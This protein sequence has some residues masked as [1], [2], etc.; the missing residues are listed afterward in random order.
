[1]LE[2]IFV[3]SMEDGEFHLRVTTKTVA[4]PCLLCFYL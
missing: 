3:D 1:M 2:F 4:R